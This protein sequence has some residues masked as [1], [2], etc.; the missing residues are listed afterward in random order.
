MSRRCLGCRIKKSADHLRF[1]DQ[2]VRCRPQNGRIFD[3]FV[4]R[5][6]K[7]EGLCNQLR[8][9]LC[10]EFWFWGARIYPLFD[11]CTKSGGPTQPASRDVSP[12]NCLLV[13]K[14]EVLGAELKRRDLQGVLLTQRGHM[15]D[16]SASPVPR[17]LQREASR[18]RI[19]ML[20]HATH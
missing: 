9:P 12:A 8:R 5:L 6:L 7:R 11:H 19:D 15:A 4:G 14:P 1:V 2:R 20:V 10:V 13:Q 18:S 16:R 17:N 3:R